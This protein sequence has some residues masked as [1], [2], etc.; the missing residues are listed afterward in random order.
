MA[1]VMPLNTPPTM[2]TMPLALGEM[3]PYLALA[4]LATVIVV[5]V[6]IAV[7]ATMPALITAP[8]GLISTIPLLIMPLV[9]PRWLPLPRRALRMVPGIP[10][11]HFFSIF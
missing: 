10:R 8:L 7:M 5:A 6:P 4:V 3:L 11:D 1:V 2:V 9:W